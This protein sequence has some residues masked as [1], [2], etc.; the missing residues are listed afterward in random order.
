MK[1]I[2]ISWNLINYMQKFLMT[3]KTEGKHQPELFHYINS[4]KNGLIFK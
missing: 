2:F 1:L 4:V 3:I